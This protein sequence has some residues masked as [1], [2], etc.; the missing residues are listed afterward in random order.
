MILFETREEDQS[1]Q[2][3][4]VFVNAVSSILYCSNKIDRNDD[5]KVQNQTMKKICDVAFK[6]HPMP[7]SQ[8]PIMF[9]TMQLFEMEQ[10]KLFLFEVSKEN[11]RGVIIRIDNQ[12]LETQTVFEPGSKNE[13][14]KT[15]NKKV[16][17]PNVYMDENINMPLHNLIC[18]GERNNNQLCD[19]WFFSKKQILIVLYENVFTNE[20]LFVIYSVKHRSLKIFKL[21]N[22]F[23]NSEVMCF[24]FF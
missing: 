18:E 24:M 8:G 23:E 9:A 15:K 12:K 14:T 4:I 19:L 6:M 21:L 13:N 10:G 1:V 20:Y 5:I 22:K 11:V 3:Q 17:F 2:F 16:Q 7:K